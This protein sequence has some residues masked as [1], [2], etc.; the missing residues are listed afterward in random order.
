MKV[1]IKKALKW[2][3][4]L[5]FYLSMDYDICLS[6]TVLEMKVNILRKQA[7]IMQSKVA[8]HSIMTSHSLSM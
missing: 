8:L 5:A 6:K 3:I 7:S 1:Q 4:S 2:R